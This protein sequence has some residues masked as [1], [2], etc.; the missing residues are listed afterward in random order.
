MNK[1]VLIFAHNSRDV[2]YALLALVSGYQAAKNLQVPVSL[3]TDIHTVEWMQT[4]NLYEKAEKIFDKIITVEKPVTSSV[5]RLNDGTYHNK[6]VPFINNNRASAWDITPYDRT[7]LIDADYF[8]FSKNMSEYWNYDSEIMIAAEMIDIRGDRLGTLDRWVSDTGIPLRW[9]TTVM[10]TKNHNTKIFFDLV[11]FIKDNYEYYSDLFRFDPR[12]FRNDIAFSIAFHI[13][14]GFEVQK[15]SL[16]PGVLTIQ[17][18]DLIHSISKMGV[19]SLINDLTPQDKS[20][21]SSVK[22][23]DVHIMNKQAV[24]RLA[25][26]I[27]EKV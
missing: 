5:R 4:S 14:D 26:D 10:F 27:L 24:I 19:V 12:T 3:A 9:A 15:E 16:L 25:N 23:R 1:G 6:I 2:D 21:L 20:I 11:N 13:L 17:D 7:L 22:N 18:K 8:I